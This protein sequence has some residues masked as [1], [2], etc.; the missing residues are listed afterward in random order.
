MEINKKYALNVTP[1]VFAEQTGKKE[2]AYLLREQGYVCIAGMYEGVVEKIASVSDG[3]YEY[4]IP[5]YLW[6]WFIPYV[7]PAI[8]TLEEAKAPEPGKHNF[9]DGKLFEINKD[10]IKTIEVGSSPSFEKLEIQ[11]A[12]GRNLTTFAVVDDPVLRTEYLMKFVTEHILTDDPLFILDGIM[13]KTPEEKESYLWELYKVYQRKLA[14]NK[15]HELVVAERNEIDK[16]LSTYE[17]NR[18][19]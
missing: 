10:S 17:Y 1:E 2:L 7:E 16:L 3:V 5:E 6:C 9:I 8:A 4:E 15:I 18:I 12:Y 14:I 19:N 13:D 11:S